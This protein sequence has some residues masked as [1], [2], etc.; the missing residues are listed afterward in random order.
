MLCQLFQWE[1]K[2]ASTTETKIIAFITNACIRTRKTL[3]PVV[4]NSGGNNRTT[5]FD[6]SIFKFLLVPFPL[7]SESGPVLLDGVRPDLRV[8]SNWS[9]VD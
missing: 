5:M 3:S 8:Q 9:A 4:E 1:G 7:L 6:V 2:V